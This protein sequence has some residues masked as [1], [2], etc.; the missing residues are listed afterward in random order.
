MLALLYPYEYVSD[1]Y[2]IDYRKLYGQGFRAVIFDIDNT[3]VHHGASATPEVEQL[4]AE[5][6]QMG[7]QTGVLSDNTEER[8]RSFLQNIQ[9]EYVCEAGK[10]GTAG[11]K[12]ILNRLGV[13][14]ERAVYIGDQ[15]FTDVLG[16]NRS[17]VASILVPFLRRPEETHFG[18]RRQLER[19]ILH[20]YHRNKRC[21][22]RLGGVQRREGTVCDC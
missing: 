13:S 12:A 1:V 22:H 14:Q 5:L 8:V 15:I 19:L 21:Q 16:A 9:A 7:F 6:K 11:F 3:L 18:K 20:F 2:Q 17:G 4:F 10:P